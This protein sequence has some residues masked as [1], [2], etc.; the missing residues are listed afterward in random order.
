MGLI[1]RALSAPAAE[2]VRPGSGDAALV[3]LTTG[4][5]R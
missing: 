3:G 2:A 4:R 5:V 1:T